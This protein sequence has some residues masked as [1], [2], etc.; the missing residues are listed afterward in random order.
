MDSHA[1]SASIG[2][3]AE[4]HLALLGALA[5]HDRRAPAEIE[6]VDVEAAQ[7]ADPQAAAVQQLEHG[8]V[9]TTSPLRLVVGRRTV[10][11]GVQLGVPTARAAGGPRPSGPAA[12]RWGRRR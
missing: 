2:H 11:Q 5:P 9:A 10:E 8:V 1:V 4:R 12:T 3:V 6:V 7:L